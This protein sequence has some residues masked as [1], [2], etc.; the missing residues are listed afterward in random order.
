MISAA[1]GLPFKPDSHA[2]Y[3]NGWIQAIKRDYREIFPACADAE[4]I[5]DYILGFAPRSEEKTV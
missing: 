4:R 5:K 1:T 2:A 3:V